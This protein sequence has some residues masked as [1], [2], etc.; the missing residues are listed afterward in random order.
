VVG[1]LQH[2]HVRRLLDR[3]REAPQPRWPLTIT[4][5]ANVGSLVLSALI[6]VST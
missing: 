4:M 6:I 2:A 1:Y 3:H 5:I